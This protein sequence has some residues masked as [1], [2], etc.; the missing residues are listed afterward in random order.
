MLWRE[1]VERARRSVV[2]YRRRAKELRDAGYTDEARTLEVLM[3]SSEAHQSVLNMMIPNLRTKIYLRSQEK[4]KAAIAVSRKYAGI[5]G[6]VKVRME[7]GSI[8]IFPRRNYLMMKDAE[9]DVTLVS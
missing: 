3:R 4:P 9:R 1:G 8:R 7:D 2:F 5:K 6:T